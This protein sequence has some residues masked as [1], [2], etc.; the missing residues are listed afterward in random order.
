MYT[1][2]RSTLFVLLL[3]VAALSA[4]AGAQV[5]IA[6]VPA[7]SE[8]YDV[9]VDTMHNKTYVTNYCGTTPSC[10]PPLSPGTVTIIDGVTLTTQT[11]TVGF[12][13]TYLA[14]NSMT[15]KIYV[16]NNCGPDRNCHNTNATVT[17][18]D[19][20]TLTTQT[21][22]CSPR[23]S[24]RKLVLRAIEAPLTAPTRWPTSDPDT[25][26][27][28]TTGTLQ[29]STLRGLARATVRSPAIRPTRSGGSRSAACGAVV[30]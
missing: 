23:R 26:G 9:Q 14:V 27:S 6:T 11:V 8:P 30:S 19:G 4:S 7:Q 1:M 13:P 29:V 17:A 12:G 2:P 5:L 10:Q 18:I 28:N 25:R 3:S 16:V 21:V 20:A 22:N 24:L 15:N